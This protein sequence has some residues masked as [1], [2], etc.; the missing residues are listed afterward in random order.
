MGTGKNT[1]SGGKM[2]RRIF[3]RLSILLLLG[4]SSN[5]TP[6][7]K[8]KIENE[9]GVKVIKNPRKPHYGEVIFDLEEDLS[10]GNEEDENYMFYRIRDIAVDSKGNIFVVNMSN[11]RIQIIIASGEGRGN[12]T[13][14]II[15]SNNIHSIRLQSGLP[16]TNDRMARYDRGNEWSYSCQKSGRAPLW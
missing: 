8:G 14:N 5:Q 7:W 13:Q 4:F 11:F 12:D 2:Q 10:I 9:N 6:Q 16:K 15:A 1:F 3:L